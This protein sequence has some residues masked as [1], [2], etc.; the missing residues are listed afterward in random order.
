MANLANFAVTIS[1]L[2]EVE[3]E[4]EDLVTSD[5]KHISTHSGELKLKSLMFDK[6]RP[7][8]TPSIGK[9]LANTDA[10]SLHNDIYTPM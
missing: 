2:G 9:K 6:H 8:P 10:H 5:R 1:K 4:R 7:P 3:E